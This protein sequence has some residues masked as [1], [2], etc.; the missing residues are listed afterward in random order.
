MIRIEDLRICQTVMYNGVKCR[1]ANS[2]TE[3]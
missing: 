2:S 3:S 1:V